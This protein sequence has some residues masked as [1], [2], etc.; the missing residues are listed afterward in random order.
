MVTMAFA[1]VIGYMERRLSSPDI[2]FEQPSTGG[3]T[4]TLWTVVMWAGRVLVAGFF[5]MSAYGHFTKTAMM[6][7]YAASKGVPMAQVSTIVT[8]LMML[9]GA[10]SVL[11][12]WHVTYGV[13]L[14][15]LF[16]VPTA[17]I[18]HNYWTVPDPMAKMGERVNFWKN[19]TIAGALL[20]YAAALHH[21]Y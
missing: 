11:T 9:A 13:A 3:A 18:M 2:M 10:L 15:V 5:L 16:L 7:G 19:I 21:V 4:M 1:D 14:L 8:G 12:G 17:F 20:L 6:A